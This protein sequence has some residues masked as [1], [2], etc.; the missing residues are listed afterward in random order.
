MTTT[1]SLSCLCFMPRPVCI[2]GLDI[3]SAPYLTLAELFMPHNNGMNHSNIAVLWKAGEGKRNQGI[4]FYAFQRIM[5]HFPNMQERFMNKGWINAFILV[6][7]F[8]LNIKFIV[9]VK[10]SWGNKLGSFKQRWTDSARHRKICFK[11][12]LATNSILFMLFFVYF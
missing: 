9:N 2:K 12:N 4:Q 10:D 8:N 3:P 5:K 7:W 11:N 6:C 1:T